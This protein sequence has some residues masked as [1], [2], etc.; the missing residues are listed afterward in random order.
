MLFTVLILLF[1]AAMLAA[2]GYSLY[3]LMRGQGKGPRVFRGLAVRVGLALTL[4]L[5]V[6]IG[7]AT[8]QLRPSAPWNRVHVEA[9]Q[10]ANDIGSPPGSTAP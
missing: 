5:L 6:L 9:E 2:L 8:G 1:A 7:L 3:A 10:P 4:L